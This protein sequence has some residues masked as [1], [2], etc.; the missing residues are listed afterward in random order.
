MCVTPQ[1]VNPILLLAGHHLYSWSESVLT[2]DFQWK[3]LE[4][5][6]WSD[7]GL[8]LFLLAFW[9]WSL[10]A[11]WCAHPYSLLKWPCWLRNYAARGCAA[12]GFCW[13]ANP[14]SPSGVQPREET[15]WSDQYRF[16]WHQYRLSFSVP[17]CSI[18]RV[19]SIAR[20]SSF[21][22][23]TAGPFEMSW[24]SYVCFRGF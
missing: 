6:P 4:F 7:P 24:E 17:I 1:D 21:L 14:S 5:C 8:F 16:V 11:T 12:A 22:T 9:E 18:L 23:A 3:K 10:P 20:W 13:W 2:V 15:M 19:V